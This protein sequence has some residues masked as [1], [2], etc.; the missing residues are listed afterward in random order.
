MASTY[1]SRTPSSASNRKTWT[2]SGWVK[3]GSLSD[4]NQVLFEGIDGSGFPEKLQFTASDILEY[5]HDI[6]GTDYTVFVTDRSFRDTNAWYHIVFAKDT[7]QSTE[8]DRIKIYVNGEQQSLSEF[9][10]GY[11]P[12]NYDGTINDTV[13][14][15]IGANN[16][17]YFN[18]SMSHIHFIDGTAYDASAFGSTDATTGEWKIKTSPSVTYG[19]NG[20]FILKDGNSVTDQ[21]GN[22]NN[23]SVG[24]GTLTNTEDNPSNVFATWNPLDGATSLGN[25]TFTF[26][27]TRWN[28]ETG[29]NKC[30][31]RST[32][33][34]TS[35][36]YYFEMK[37]E[38]PSNNCAI[39]ISDRPAPN[40]TDE[41]GA[42]AYDYCYQ[43]TN[44]ETINNTTQSSGYGNS[45]TTDDIVMCAL[46]LDNNKLYFGKNGTWQNSGDPTS[47]ATGTGAA[48]SVT[49][50]SSTNG[51]AY[52][53]CGA[54]LTGA[55]NTRLQ[56]NFGN[57]YFQ[58]TAVSSA[59]TNASGN[60][61]FEYDVP[62]GYTALST[63]G[64]NL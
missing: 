3:R 40:L 38:T 26:G 7:T 21:S 55:N 56:A 27:N 42:G 61:I 54:D 58:T 57:G 25:S 60:G 59:G 9:Q 50:P 48:Y 33:G 6:A 36:K 63:K 34:M 20:F 28:S 31:T 22:G 14:H 2:W 12:Q 10:L 23:W 30:W 64:L 18:G 15:Y 11:P 49:T 41:L 45:Y 24:G 17:E 37:V 8:A 16:G 47:G 52:F 62:T 13:A 43:S 4:S 51:G 5:D 53:F 46:D 44:G 39:G 29:S 35:G 1:L 32:L 19:T